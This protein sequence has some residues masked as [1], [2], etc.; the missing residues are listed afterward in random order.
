M[1]SNAVMIFRDC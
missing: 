1:Q